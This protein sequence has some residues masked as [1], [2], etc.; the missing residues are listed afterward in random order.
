MQFHFHSQ[1]TRRRKE[2]ILL[3]TQSEIY[4]YFFGEN[5]QYRRTHTHTCRKKE[6]NQIKRYKP[7]IFNIFENVHRYAGM[8]CGWLCHQYW[9]NKLHNQFNKRTKWKYVCALSIDFSFVSVR[10]CTNRD[11]CFANS[12]GPDSFGPTYT[13]V[14]DIKTSSSVW[15][16]AHQERERI[17][18]AMVLLL[19]KLQRKSTVREWQYTHTQTQTTLTLTTTYRFFFVYLNKNKMR[20]NKSATK[21]DKD[22]FFSAFLKEKRRNNFTFFDQIAFWNFFPP[23]ASSNSHDANDSIFFLSGCFRYSGVW[24]LQT[25]CDHHNVIKL[26]SAKNQAIRCDRARTKKGSTKGRRIKNKIK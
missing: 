9:S 19:D 1:Q 14:V 10:T 2:F 13:R 17:F 6:E 22:F 12:F 15:H 3:R 4:I 25:V 8:V 23:C 7:Q 5:I 20:T 18:D 11:C 24:M 21:N 16:T 26:T